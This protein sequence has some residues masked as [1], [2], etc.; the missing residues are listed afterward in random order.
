MPE[1]NTAIAQ[2]CATRCYSMKDIAQAFEIH[3][4]TVSQIVKMTGN[5]WEMGD[6]VARM[7]PWPGPW[8]LPP[9]V[10]LVMLARTPTPPR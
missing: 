1:R 10:A 6:P 9:R 2:A 3:Y 7:T 8:V 4:A 5:F